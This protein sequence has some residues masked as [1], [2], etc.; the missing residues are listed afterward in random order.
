MP[1]YVAPDV[2]YS[3]VLTA[4]MPPEQGARIRFRMNQRRRLNVALRAPGWIDADQPT[5]EWPR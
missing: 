2:D 5:W 3:V 4:F 1:L